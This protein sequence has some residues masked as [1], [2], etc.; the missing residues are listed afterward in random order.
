MAKIP[1]FGDPELLPKPKLTRPSRR[2]MP[3]DAS[4]RLKPDGP[5]FVGPLGTQPDIKKLP[6]TR[7]S[8]DSWTTIEQRAIVMV[9]LVRF[10]QD[11]FPVFNGWSVIE[12][13]SSPRSSALRPLNPYLIIRVKRK[14]DEQVFEVSID[15]PKNVR[16]SE[17]LFAART[18]AAGPALL[19][20]AI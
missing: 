11:N 12:K 13:N 14:S 20:Q 6:W 17:I 18:A 15:Y 5:E 1:Q 2:S 8:F 9:F 7:L 16:D 3:F 10:F 19:A 4:G